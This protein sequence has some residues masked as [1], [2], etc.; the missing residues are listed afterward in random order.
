M[1]IM[2]N[3]LMIT[4]VA[5]V[6]AYS[7][8]YSPAQAQPTP[9]PTRPA[10]PQQPRAVLPPKPGE[11]VSPETPNIILIVVDDL[12]WGDLGKYGQKLIKTPWIDKLAAEGMRFTQFYAGAP[13]G[14]AS[15]SALFTGKHT[16]HTYI[17]GNMPAS[18][19][20]IDIVIPQYL[21]G[22]AQYETIAI[23]KWNLGTKGSPGEPKKKGFNHWF[24]F[25]DQIHANNHYPEFFW[26]Y[27]PGYGSG[28]KKYLAQD[29]DIRV[30]FNA[31]G[32]RR[33]YSTDL[34]TTAATKAIGLYKPQWFR[35]N[36]PFFLYLS[37]TAPHIN[38][39]LAQKTGNGWEVPTNQP[40]SGQKWPRP[41]RSKAAMITRLDS[42]VGMVMH[43]LKK[44][45]MDEDTL[46]F[47]TSDNGP[48]QEG[49]SNPAF[50]QSAGP[51][52][53]TKG[54][55]HEGG[56]RVPMIV[57]WTGKV[58]PGMVSDEI[59]AHWDVLPT[60]LSAARV[61]KPREIDGISFMP[62]LLGIGQKPQ[63]EYLYWET[64]QPEYGS[65]QAARKGDW[66]V[67]RKALGDPLEL[68]NLKRD[69]S[70]SQNVARN[71]PEIIKEFESYLRSARTGSRL[72]PIRQPKQTAR[73]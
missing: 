12:G 52:R 36:R 58:K 4:L 45:D 7:L 35:D 11:K 33:G 68:Y 19:R 13:L 46:I 66:K 69:P 18:L 26:R 73:R 28:P 32:Q 56:V 63:H 9:T 51:F 1:K 67:I 24:G 29:G 55:L 48:A 53:G 42:A 20:T 62:T 49:G 25:V 59:L 23:G 40:Y 47:F 8:T 5:S 34:L 60:I 27:E 72:W 54:H 6:W 37:Y 16:G 57:R 15:R 39:N 50:F 31:N 17:R 14:N 44:H 10:S 22:N 41:K 71:N 70:E 64:H 3:K 65:R 43:E 2:F 30:P 21:L 61:S 38:E